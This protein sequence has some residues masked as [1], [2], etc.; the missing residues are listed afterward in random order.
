MSRLASLGVELFSK[1]A[2]EETV[3][4]LAPS[5]PWGQEALAEIS[6]GQVWP[7]AVHWSSTSGLRASTGHALAGTDT[8][9]FRLP[10]DGGRHFVMPA[11]TDQRCFRHPPDLGVRRPSAASATEKRLVTKEIRV[12]TDERR[13]R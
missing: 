7:R 4:A 6:N 11:G 5:W 8:R 10:P 1:E 12:G 3:K 9:G 2:L 13:F